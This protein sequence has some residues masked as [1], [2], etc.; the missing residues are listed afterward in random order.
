MTLTACAGN[1]VD[2]SASVPPLEPLVYCEA[3]AM[4]YDYLGIPNVDD[5]LNGAERATVISTVEKAALALPQ[6]VDLG[7][8]TA[9]ESDILNKTVPVILGLYKNP[10]LAKAEAPEIAKALG[11][12][13]E[14]LLELNSEENNAIAESARTSLQDYCQ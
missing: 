13:E 3:V 5:D 1:N 4:F 11:I 2:D 6:G 7:V 10:D 12:P 14:E 9:E 8:L